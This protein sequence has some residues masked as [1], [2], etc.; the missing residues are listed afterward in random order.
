MRRAALISVP[1]AVVALVVATGCSGVRDKADMAPRPFCEAAYQ[2]DTDI[3]ASTSEQQLAMVATMAA[4]APP[5]IK[6]EAELW[7]EG[8]ERVVT[9]R[10]DISDADRSKYEAAST[11]LQRFAIKKCKLLEQNGNGGIT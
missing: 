7:L 9:R 6:R 3:G 5:E 4:E 1:T 10:E 11:D 2:L 8:M